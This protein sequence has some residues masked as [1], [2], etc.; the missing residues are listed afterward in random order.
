MSDIYVDENYELNDKL[1]EGSEIGVLS[2]CGVGGPRGGKL[3]NEFSNTFEGKAS[4]VFIKD[5]KRSW[6]NNGRFEDILDMA[7]QHL[8][9]S[10][11]KRIFA[12]GNSMGGCGALLA[13]HFRP[14]IERVYSF[15]PQADPYNDS[16]WK[17][18]TSRIQLIR[19]PTFATLECKTDFKIFFGTDADDSHQCELFKAANKEITYVDQTAHNAIMVIKLRGDMPAIVKE[20][21][22]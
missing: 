1:L 14:D 3:I 6:W 15:V 9:D 11:C 21:L 19:W 8:K 5:T 16:R 12:I 22:K 17:H 18:L 4:L 20:F 7:I 10:G 2:F 13:S